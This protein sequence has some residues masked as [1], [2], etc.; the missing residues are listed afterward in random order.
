MVAHESAI[1]I[2]RHSTIIIVRPL[3]TDVVHSNDHYRILTKL[4]GK[5]RHICMS[6]HMTQGHVH[7]SHMYVL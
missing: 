2:S 3:P 7:T 5:G 6:I 1:L 4:F